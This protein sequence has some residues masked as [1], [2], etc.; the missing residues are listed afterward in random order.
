MLNIQ[1]IYHLALSSDCLL[2]FPLCCLQEFGGGT[3][4]K[5]GDTVCLVV[6]HGVAFRNEHVFRV[7]EGL[8]YLLIRVPLKSVQFARVSAKRRRGRM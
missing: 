7:A 2:L 5:D 8:F 4:D 6:E 1:G 3:G